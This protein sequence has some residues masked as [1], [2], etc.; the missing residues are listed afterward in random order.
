MGGGGGGTRTKFSRTPGH[1]TRTK[2]NNTRT[3]NKIDIF[4]WI[5]FNLKKI[6]NLYTI[7]LNL[8]NNFWKFEYFASIFFWKK[9]WAQSFS[10]CFLIL[11]LSYLKGVDVI[12]IDSS[13][14]KIFQFHMILAKSIPFL[15]YHF[16]IFQYFHFH[17]I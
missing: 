14:K 11:F 13:S 9:I 8:N 1:D 4:N 12:W 15:I 16:N 5:L 2:K 3:K 17:Q 10:Y 6:Y 7:Y